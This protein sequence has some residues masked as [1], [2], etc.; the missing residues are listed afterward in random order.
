MDFFAAA[1]SG[2]HFRSKELTFKLVMKQWRNSF[3]GEGAALYQTSLAF[4]QETFAG[5]PLE[6]SKLFRLTL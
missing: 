4:P 1:R 3:K 5:V 2:D 6:I